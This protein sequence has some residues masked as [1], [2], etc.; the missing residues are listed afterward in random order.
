VHPF[1]RQGQSRMMLVLEDES[2]QALDLAGILR[3]LGCSLLGPVGSGAE[4]LDL[5]DRRRPDLALLDARP[6]DGGEGLVRV[7][8]A[9]TTSTW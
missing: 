7:A 2:F 4:A 5:L 1:P 8:A 3:G 6:R 9:L